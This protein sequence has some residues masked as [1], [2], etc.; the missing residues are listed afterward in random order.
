MSQWVLCQKIRFLGQKLWPV[1][2]EHTERGFNHWVPYRA[3]PFKLLPMIW[4]VQLCD[5]IKRSWVM[6]VKFLPA[7]LRCHA[8]KVSKCCFFLLGP[9]LLQHYWRLY[10]KDFHFFCL[11]GDIDISFF[12]RCV[13]FPQCKIYVWGDAFRVHCIISDIGYTNFHQ[14]DH[15]LLSREINGWVCSNKSAHSGPET[16][17]GLVASVIQV[18]EN[19]LR[20]KNANKA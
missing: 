8:W 6:T 5:F 7:N 18:T 9:Q 16:G 13:F 4:A 15:H 19:H 17:Q 20:A 11:S 14:K 12:T 10:Q 1:A 3:Q 2:G